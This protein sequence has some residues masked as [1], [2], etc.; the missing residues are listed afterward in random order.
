MTA[1]N[2]S[3]TGAVVALAISQ[4]LLAVPLALLS[5][6]A[7]DVIP[8]FDMG[9]SKSGLFKKIASV[10]TVAAAIFT[11]GLPFLL[12]NH[13]SAWQIFACM[14]V[15]MSP[16]FIWGWRYFRFRSLEGVINE[17]MSLFSAVHKKIQWSET[18]K[19]IYVE[20]VWFA[21]AWAAIVSLR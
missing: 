9:A 3:L 4:P 15:A 6:F 21:A 14:L 19:G 8:H 2:H 20:A 12:N 5:H 1:T 17:P 18:P 11:L 13:R 16:D 10:D 7:V